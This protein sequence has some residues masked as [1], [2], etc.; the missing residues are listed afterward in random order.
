MRILLI[1]C[2]KLGLC[3]TVHCAVVG[4]RVTVWERERERREEV[5]R[6]PVFT[7]D[8]TG[9]DV[10]DAEPHLHRLWSTVPR[11]AIKVLDALG[12]A[13]GEER[14]RERERPLIWCW[15]TSRLPRDPR[16]ATTPRALQTSYDS[17]RTHHCLSLSLS[18]SPSSLGVRYRL[19]SAQLPPDPS[20]PS[21]SAT[22][23]SSLHK[24][25][26]WQDSLHPLSLS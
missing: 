19:A 12:E 13:V 10:P 22:T 25:T 15:C 3:V 23:Q 20:P 16:V 1:G 24:V 2:G 4:H 18:L 7:S 5:R 8:E 6:G 14:E 9:T 21:A 17:W 11:S 26:S